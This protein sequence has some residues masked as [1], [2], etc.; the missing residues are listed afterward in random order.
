ME[1]KLLSGHIIKK[2]EGE[3][4]E[5]LRK[6]FFYYSDGLIRLYPGKWIY[7]RSYERYANHILSFEVSLLRVI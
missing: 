4:E 7:M 2:V 1:K 6:R 5:E 3:E